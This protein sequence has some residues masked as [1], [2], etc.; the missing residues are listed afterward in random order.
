MI[1]INLLPDV[2]LHYLRTQRNKRLVFTFAGLT[3]AAAVA[4]VVLLALHVYV[5]QAFHTSQ[6]QSDID[7]LT[8]EYTNIDNLD[9]I[10]TVREQLI[11]LPGL[12]AEKPASTRI[13][14]FLAKLVPS[15]I[16]IGE[17]SVDYVDNVMR[18]EG[19][20]ED[21]K[22]VNRFADI[23]KN[24]TYSSGDGTTPSGVFSG[25]E[26]DIGVTGEDGLGF[27][28][29]MDFDPEIFNITNDEVDIS[30][31]STTSTQSFIRTD[32]L[33]DELDIPDEE[34]QP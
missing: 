13:S 28:T 19:V 6:L 1:Q 8:A 25:V 31:P 32:S 12:H 3:A 10:L 22:S 27:D 9:T 7:N 11:E 4:V 23:L 15:D 5:N 20:G 34:I 29:R 14:G 33:F 21:T 30:V 2:K 26:F 18:I 16:K 17:L 24:A